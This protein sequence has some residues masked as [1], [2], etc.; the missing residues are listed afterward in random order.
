[1]LNSKS[2][3][4]NGLFVERG[5]QMSSGLFIPPNTGF[6]PL[7]F[8]PP[9][10][11]PLVGSQP[12]GNPYIGGF[13]RNEMA[14]IDEFVNYHLAADDH[15]PS[16]KA[17]PVDE[18]LK[19]TQYELKAEAKAEQAQEEKTRE[20]KR[21]SYLMTAASQPLGR[22]AH[23][24]LSNI[25][26]AKSNAGLLC[27]FDYTKGLERLL[28]SPQMK[29]KHELALKIQTTERKFHQISS[30]HSQTEL[31]A[32]EEQFERVRLKY[33]R[34]FSSLATPACMWRRTG[35]IVKFNR[36]FAHLAHL[37]Q[38]HPQQQEKRYWI[39][40]ILDQTSFENYYQQFENIAWQPSQKAVLTFCNI[41]I[42][43]GGLE[44]NETR[45]R[46][47]FSFTISRDRNQLP[48]CIVGNF[49][50]I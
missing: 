34:I 4:T 42:S 28:K 14:D 22:S 13:C 41:V 23:D 31:E 19:E 7:S 3:P 48:L 16:N 20:E 38:Q 30:R 43:G 5:V 27:P 8:G 6:V 39:Y 29:D 10:P 45:K 12:V 25:I 26:A 40:E 18:E 46:C 37:S 44:T 24:K 9:P 11:H 1:M 21:E 49:I 50:P 47:T 15:P 32:T 2:N 33:E 17:A 36:E 35:E